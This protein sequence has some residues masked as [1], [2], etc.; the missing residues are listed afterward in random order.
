MK[1]KMLLLLVLLQFIAC[2]SFGQ[3]DV[4]TKEFTEEDQVENY[5]FAMRD[6]LGYTWFSYIDR[7]N[8]ALSCFDGK[9][10]RTFFSSTGTNIFTLTNTI[11][12]KYFYRDREGLVWK[13]SDLGIF[14][15]INGKPTK[16][17][18]RQNGLSSDTVLNL[19]FDINNNIW[20]VTAKD[21]CI[22]K[23][24][25]GGYKIIKL[26]T[27]YSYNIKDQLTGTNMVANV[28]CFINCDPFG[29]TWWGLSDL[30]GN[31]KIY[32]TNNYFATT[33]VDSFHF[34]GRIFYQ[35]TFRKGLLMVDSSNQVSFIDSSGT[36]NYIKSKF[37]FITIDKHGNIYGSSYQNGYMIIYRDQPQRFIDFGESP[38]AFR[39]PTKFPSSSYLH[40]LSG[41]AFVM[42]ENYLCK[43]EEK[44]AR[45]IDISGLNIKNANFFQSTEDILWASE[46]HKKRLKQVL[47]DNN[48]SI[49]NLESDINGVDIIGADQ[50][51]ST[52]Y[53]M[54][55]K[56]MSEKPFLY[57]RGI[58]KKKKNITI[59]FL[60]LTKSGIW[61]FSKKKFVKIEQNKIKEEY[62][63]DP[64][65]AA[66]CNSGGCFVLLPSNKIVYLNKNKITEYPLYSSYLPGNI[67][68]ASNDRFYLI[69]K[70]WTIYLCDP[71][72]NK[73]LIKIQGIPPGN[74][75]TWSHSGSII[76][77]TKGGQSG[78][79]D[80]E[81]VILIDT[82]KYPSFK[83]Y[84]II[85]MDENNRIFVT[86]DPVCNEILKFENN[87]FTLYKCNPAN[88]GE[89]IFMSKFMKGTDEIIYFQGTKIFRYDKTLHQF[90]LIKKMGSEVG[91]L[92][93]GLVMNDSLYIT[94][95][96]P[97]LTAIGLK[98]CHIT[99]PC[100]SLQSIVYSSKDTSQRNNY[101][102]AYGKNFAV[103]YIAIEKFYQKNIVYQTRILGSNDST[104]SLETKNETKELNNL[105]PRTYRFE[106]RTKGESMVWSPPIGFDFTV[107]PP[108]YLTAWAYG[109]YSLGFIVLL[110]GLS[111][112]RTIALR[113]EK[114]KLE[115][116]VKQRT[117]EVLQQKEEA[118]KQRQIAEKSAKIKQDF[119]SNMSHEIRTPLNAITGY[120]ELS[121]KENVCDKVRNNLK[122]VKLSSAHL[123]KLVDDILD[124]SKLESGSMSFHPV[125]FDLAQLTEEVKTL[126]HF[127][128]KEKDNTLTSSIH[129]TSTCIL[130]GDKDKLIQV[131][132]NLLDNAAKFTR[133]GKINM[134]SE[135]L[136]ISSNKVMVHVAISD[137]GI[138]IAP[139][140]LTSIFES[141]AQAD[142]SI[143]RTYGGSGL[144]LSISKKI[145][146]LQGGEIR[147]NS[148]KQIGSVF[149][150]QLPFLKGEETLIVKDVQP[151]YQNKLKGLRILAAEDD[152]V[153]QDL[154]QQLLQHWD[155]QVDFA[156]SGEKV[157]D[158]LKASTYQLILLDIHMP[159][160]N[161][162][163]VANQIRTYSHS[164]VKDIP[165]IALTADVLP[166]TKE[167]MK[168]AGINSHIYKPIDAVKLNE[169]IHRTLGLHT[170]P[171][172]PADQT[173]KW[174]FATQH[175]NL[176]YLTKNY[177]SNKNY[178]LSSLQKGSIKLHEYKSA[179]QT[180]F[181]EKD[182][183]QLLFYTHRLKG[184]AGVLG[185]EA[186]REKL[187]TIDRFVETEGHYELISAEIESISR[188]TEIASK[189]IT[190]VITLISRNETHKTHHQPL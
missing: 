186:I 89:Y 145:I 4:E 122:A 72:N 173:S 117:A 121:L 39:Y 168:T 29:T 18:D 159:V 119:L 104:W 47:I 131:L 127:K 105:S 65:S 37:N 179:I 172:L 99:Y 71:L 91:I 12:E 78:W 111:Q 55:E 163:E 90:Y 161:G 151:V 171:F 158:L 149:S 20:I 88:T 38:H 128:I 130:Y 3:L 16:I 180:A 142:N 76:T 14:K 154:L 126:M 169:E 19:S 75:I 6:K 146:E 132:I 27:H 112:W 17:L 67:L 157:L 139:E 59:P 77:F 147:V 165:I 114:T 30:N 129:T 50:N 124:I 136:D 174:E 182:V 108:W 22:A 152:P 60:Q 24:I 134:H 41:E 51:D 70:D 49:Y 33:K 109:G 8:G 57:H 167:K 84:C 100:L 144:G 116:T 42:C 45:I 87:H 115:Q 81:K 58:C 63:I 133:K 181:K 31:S 40:L 68:K 155:I 137:T 34:K 135:V 54:E 162:F 26:P 43:L 148:I 95:W 110:F 141:F 187:I 177:G 52:I 166:A 15:M 32:K 82:L 66:P 150:F 113:K 98:D 178:V 94:G 25:Q 93:D 13:C 125:H 140:K 183:H 185:I 62:T 73:T 10:F 69:S 46:I 138:G 160:L 56:G 175:F 189:E 74:L 64:S 101:D 85:T 35:K 123:K 86:G 153:N 61:A 9:S 107:L 170:V 11:G 102:I 2:Y 28:K 80:N 23:K 97:K 106:V 164:P 176:D 190:E 7:G 21:I 53:L 103:N 188:I 118:D 156:G 36:L 92:W 184:I 48:S 83:K 120:T 44:Q 1:T 79:I 143:S 96:G 5:H